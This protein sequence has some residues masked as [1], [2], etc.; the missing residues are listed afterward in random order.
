MA[1]LRHL[2]GRAVPLACALVLLSN[3]SAPAQAP[4]P[5]PDDPAYFYRDPRPERLADIFAHVQSTATS[6][7]AYPP[8]TGL[9]AAVFKSHPEHIDR[10]VPIV[11]NA[12]ASYALITA[13]RLSGQPAKAE[14]L[15]ARFASLGFDQTLN[16]EFADIPTRFEDLRITRPTHLDILWGA[17]F[18]AGD[19]RYV[20]PIIDYFAAAA[21]TSEP[22]AIDIVKT[23]IEITGGPKGT[24]AGLKAK[25]GD[26]QTMQ[27]IFAATALWAITANSRQHDYVRQTVA[28][29]I[30]DRPGTPATKTLSALTGLK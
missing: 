14:M 8:L 1:W 6:W 30:G 26:A 25:Y 18:A 12:E 15:R 7:E 11:A 16:A 27:L 22:V 29:Y 19:S 2:V 20:T 28:R 5:S 4:T 21:N 10:L 24:I 23:T 17:S 3:L 9:L 13:A